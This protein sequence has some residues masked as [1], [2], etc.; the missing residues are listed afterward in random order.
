MLDKLVSILGAVVALG[1]LIAVH[2]LGHYLVA[3]WTGMRVLR[4]SIGFGP[5][6]KRWVRNEIEYLVAWFPLGGYVQ[7]A[8]MNPADEEARDDPRSYNNRPRWARA[9]VVAAG[10]VFSYAL[11]FVCYFFAFVGSGGPSQAALRV[12]EVVP[13]SAAEEAGLQPGD[14]IGVI[15]DLR[16]TD[17][18]T[19][20]DYVD[21]HLGQEV[22]LGIDRGGTMMT[23]TAKLPAAASATGVLGI[24]FRPVVSLSAGQAFAA[25]GRAV[26]GQTSAILTA[27]GNLVVKPSEVQ[28]GGVPKIMQQLGQSAQRG[29]SDLILLIAGLSVMF[30]LLNALPVPALDGSKLFILGL[31]A[32]VR[33]DVP[34]R[35]QV[36]FH[37]VGFIALLLLMVVVSGFDV[38]EMV[39]E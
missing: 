20:V 28:V 39:Q 2:E 32:L 22:A 6:L 8:G 38:W 3:R 13:G 11:A 18:Q 21:Q 15:G 17:A 7:V 29:L 4:F 19:F 1:V 30:G 37:S 5:P 9:A 14:D 26:L 34:A 10:P 16:V 31:E 24:R 35:F 33:R 25:A 27:L 12:T 36:V 23:L